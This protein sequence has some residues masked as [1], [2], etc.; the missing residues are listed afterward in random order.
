MWNDSSDLGIDSLDAQGGP[1]WALVVTSYFSRVKFAST[2]RCEVTQL[3]SAIYR[4]P[5]TPFIPGR[6]PPCSSFCIIWRILLKQ[7]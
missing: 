7:S 6:G 3:F 5:I 1:W 4:G 2:S